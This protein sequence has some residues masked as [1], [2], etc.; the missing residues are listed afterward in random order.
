MGFDAPY[1][2][3]ENEA[4]LYLERIRWPHG[5]ICP[6]CGS[7]D[8]HYAL[9]GKKESTAPVRQGVW[10]CKKCRK[11]FSVTVGTVFEKSHIPLHKW[12]LASFL[13]CSSK[14]GM[15]S[16]QL[17]RMLKVTYKTAWFMSHRIRYAMDKKPTTKFQGT[18]EADETYI[19]GKGH[20]K[21]GRGAENKTPVF[22]LVERNGNVMSM[23]V[24]RVTGENLKFIISQNVE[25][26]STI[27]TDDFMSYRGLDKKFASHEV[28]NHGKREYVRGN[29]HTNTIEGYFSILKRGIIGVYH[30]V[31]KNHLH[32]YLSEF[33]FRY[34]RRK[35]NDAERSVMALCGIEGKRLLY[36]DSPI[37]A[38]TN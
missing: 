2:T 6:H 15:S 10:K 8:H 33:N 19:G 38:I 16:H 27:M 37:V 1:F 26:S 9:K 18:I 11:Q 12:L 25:K 7:A 20:G 22:A 17:H 14:K 30:H 4:R 29:I 13:I 21:R 31:G 3:D 34:N 28:I 23:P 32:R 24:E 36:K 5:S 35:N